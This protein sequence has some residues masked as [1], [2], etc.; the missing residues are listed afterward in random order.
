MAAMR[1]FNRKYR[2]PLEFQKMLKV[3]V[4]AIFQKYF[5]NKNLFQYKQHSSLKSWFKFISIACKYIRF[6]VKLQL[7]QSKVFFVIA[8]LKIRK[9]TIK[10]ELIL[11]KVQPLLLCCFIINYTK[12]KFTRRVSY[13]TD[14]IVYIERR[15]M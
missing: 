12:W 11:K 10:T 1:L 5:S 4:D 8:L 15:W 2:E 6:P 9:K 7:A 14:H 13:N 3:S